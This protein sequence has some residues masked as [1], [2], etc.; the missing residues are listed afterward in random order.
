[1][2]LMMADIS[3]IIPPTLSLAERIDQVRRKAAAV[4]LA[5]TRNTSEITLT[6]NEISFVSSSSCSDN[7]DA[8]TSIANQ[9]P[10]SHAVSKASIRGEH[11]EVGVVAHQLIFSLSEKRRGFFQP[12]VEA[13][14][15]S[16]RDH[17]EGI[18]LHL[19]I[20][21]PDARAVAE[22]L[23]TAD[24]SA[25]DRQLAV[26]NKQLSKTPVSESPLTA[27]QELSIAQAGGNRHF[28]PK[29][30]NVENTITLDHKSSDAQ[31]EKVKKVPEKLWKA[32]ENLQNGAKSP[33]DITDQG[34][35]TVGPEK[36]KRE[37]SPDKRSEAVPSKQ[38]EPYV[39]QDTTS[40]S[41]SR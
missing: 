1:L 10:L 16:K 17:L 36:R 12:L 34:V 4:R 40:S 7:D 31:L 3:H 27:D 21:F 19:C 14:R 13:I 20:Q 5:A 37:S 6:T 35:H 9:G 41:C 39:S 15:D 33:S 38:K 22:S 30:S 28:V 23:L 26:D 25:I 8:V 32:S 29:K 2:S 11:S 18:L 24:D